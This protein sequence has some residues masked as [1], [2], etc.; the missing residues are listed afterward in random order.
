[1]HHTARVAGGPDGRPAHRARRERLHTRQVVWTSDGGRR[2][3]L[4][5]PLRVALYPLHAIYL[6]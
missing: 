1:M 2:E 3:M 4:Q 5:A 6:W